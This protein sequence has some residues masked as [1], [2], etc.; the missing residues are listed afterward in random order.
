MRHT[1]APLITAVVCA[2]VLPLALKAQEQPSPEQNI[3]PLDSS[4]GLV[5]CFDYYHFGSVQANLSAAVASAVSGTPVAFSG[6][7]TN[8]NPYPIVDGALY[9]KVF[10]MRGGVNDGNGPDVVD[11]FLVRGDIVIPAQ[12]SI[13]VSF[14]WNVPTY[15]QS[16]DYQIATFFTTSRK[17]NLLGLSFTDDVV[18]NTTPFKVVGENTSGVSFDKAGVTVNSAAYHFAAFPPHV[19]AADPVVVSAPITN[20]TDRPARAMV[21]W[22]VNQWDAQLRENVVQEES[23]TLTV[24]AQTTQIVSITV[25][26]TKYPV[27]LVVGTLSW[28]DTESIIGV[29]FVRDGVD[30]P[31]INFPGVASYPLVAGQPNTLFSCLHNAG[32]SDSIPDGRLDITL[33]DMRGN[34][35]HTYTFTGGITG[36][37]MGVADTFTPTRNYDSFVLDA[38]LYQGDSFTDEAHLVYDCKTLKT[39]GCTDQN[40]SESTDFSTLSFGDFLGGYADTIVYSIGALLLVLGLIFVSRK[41]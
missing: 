38:R 33:S 14:S 39:E 37:M 30:R 32:S 22:Q 20:T 8:N 27:Y 7:L 1:I 18:G 21:K 28:Q 17:F 2:L 24:P 26:D 19:N 36:A 40:S 12:S 25:T 9:V 34:P 4:P 3:T 16:G 11:Q 13:P 6:S 35:I 10:K 31:R 41:F 15:A 29:R 5:S 23:S